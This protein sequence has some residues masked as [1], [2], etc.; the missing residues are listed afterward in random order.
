[1]RQINHV[2]YSRQRQNM[3]NFQIFST[4]FTNMYQSRWFIWVMFKRDF[5]MANKRSFLGYGWLL[6]SPVLASVSWIAMNYIGVLKPGEMDIPF[7]IFILVGSSFWAFFTNM[8]GSHQG[9]F[10]SVGG[11]IGSVNFPHESA[12]A[13]QTIKPIVYF[14]I[15][16][17]FNIFILALFGIYPSFMW[18]LIPVLIIPLMLMGIALGLTMLLVSFA[19]PDVGRV[20]GYLFTLLFYITPVVF[21]PD[22]AAGRLSFLIKYNPF[23]YLISIPREIILTGQANS[24]WTLFG[25]S[26][27]LSLFVCLWVMRAFYLIEMQMHEREY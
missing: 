10:G 14:Y 3:S 26:S 6:L 7:P 19:V 2:Y 20:I 24:S 23:T 5:Y 16:S 25:L 13:L 27:L 15:S 12:I 9:V 18:L 21:Q 1:M 8:H 22:T 4:M 11:M 17:A